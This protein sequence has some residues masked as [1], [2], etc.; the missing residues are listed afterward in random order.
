MK[1]NTGV[2][3]LFLLLGL[4]SG[5]IVANLISSVDALA[6]LTKSTTVSWQPRANFDFMKYSFFIQVKLSLMSILGIVAALWIYR[7]I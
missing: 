2:L 5:S 7:K 6:F 1:K 4:I 3:I